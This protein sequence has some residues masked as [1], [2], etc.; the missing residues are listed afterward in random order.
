MAKLL[1]GMRSIDD[2]RHFLI[3]PVQGIWIAADNNDDRVRIDRQHFLD[4]LLLR[5]WQCDVRT[6]DRLLTIDQRVIA[7]KYNSDVCVACRF[8]GCLKFVRYNLYFEGVSANLPFFLTRYRSC[9][10]NV[11]LIGSLFSA[12]AAH[13]QLS[14]STL[15]CHRHIIPG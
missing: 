12:A 5:C 13:K 6:V 2:S 7:D 8:L 3:H 14:C 11:D 15:H 10:R 9:A 1:S 4:Q